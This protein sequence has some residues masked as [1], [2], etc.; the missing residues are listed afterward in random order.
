MPRASNPIDT[1]VNY[2][3]TAPLDAAVL[4]LH[5]AKG[6]VKDRQPAQVK[7]TRKRKQA[8]PTQDTAS[9]MLVGASK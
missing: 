4:A 7:A 9:E 2:F 5:V 3:K 6:I 1:V 8:A